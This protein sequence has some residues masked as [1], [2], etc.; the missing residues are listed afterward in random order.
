MSARQCRNRFRANQRRVTRQKNHK[1]CAGGNRAPRDQH[2]VARPTLRLLQ[3]CFDAEGCD[4]ARHIIGLMPNHRHNLARFER[5]ARAHHML[6]ERSATGTM[7]HFCQRGFQPRALAGRKD[8][9]HKV[10]IRHACIV[11]VSSRIDNAG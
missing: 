11:G 3:N 9:D 4:G 8:H 10:G 7:Q 2:G 1:F 5:L 6:D